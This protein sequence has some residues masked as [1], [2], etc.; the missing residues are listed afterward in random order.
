M[1]DPKLST[2]ITLAMG[3]KTSEIAFFPIAPGF[4]H[5]EQCP[6]AN[7]KDRFAANQ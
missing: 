2:P 7:K 3:K 4:F 1:S 6:S 5:Q